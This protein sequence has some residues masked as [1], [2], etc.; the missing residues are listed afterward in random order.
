MFLLLRCCWQQDACQEGKRST[1]RGC[2]A[3]KRPTER[4]RVG[5]PTA[6]PISTLFCSAHQHS[7]GC[8]LSIFRL[9]LVVGPVVVK[10]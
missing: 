5:L 2:Q 7:E 9:D 1:K 10:R 3:A 6:Q 4:Q 8:V